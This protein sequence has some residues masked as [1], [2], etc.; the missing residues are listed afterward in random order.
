M[1]GMTNLNVKVPLPIAILILI[2]C[3]P[4]AAQEK[5]KLTYGILV[6]S[7]GSMR[8]Q[9]EEVLIIAKSVVDQV[10]EHGPV[11][12]F[13]FHSEPPGRSKNAQPKV[14]I[15]ASQNEDLLLKALD[16]IYIEG[17]Q[18]TLLDAIE[19]MR[20]TLNKQ[21]PDGNKVIILITDG[22]DR[23][24]KTKRTQLVEDLRKDKVTVFAIGLVQDLEN[25][26][27]KATNL[28]RTLAEDTGGRAIFP[29]SNR[30]LDA[31]LRALAIPIQ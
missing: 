31:D 19:F 21:S 11:S 16:Q 5:P 1:H 20:A 7:T 6:D 10:H 25:G 13:D 8:T 23:T 4:C 29:E 30:H 12:I 26:K 22:E 24:S 17:G 9:F 28:L 18:T 14:R 3:L 2:F 27:S 15:E